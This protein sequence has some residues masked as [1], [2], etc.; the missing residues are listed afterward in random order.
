MTE[1]PHTR[2]AAILGGAVKGA[3]VLVVIAFV[4]V[5][6]VVPG[7]VIHTAARVGPGIAFSTVDGRDVVVISYTDDAYA[8]LASFGGND[9]RVTAIDLA[10]GETV[11][12]RGIDDTASAPT[13][14][15]AG[16]E[17]AYLL[18]FS[19]LYVIDL[20]DGSSVAHS[21]DIAGLEDFDFFP[22]EIIYSR[23]QNA[24]MLGSGESPVLE[25][26]L[27]TLEAVESDKTTVGT[28]SCVLDWRGH[29]YSYDMPEPVLVNSTSIEGGTLGFGLPTGA[30]PGTPGKRLSLVGAKGSSIA[31]GPETF[32]NGQFVAESVRNEPR[33]GACGTARSKRNVFPVDET[34]P[35]PVGISS[36]FAVVEHDV[37]ARDG[38]RA[39]SAVDTATGELLDSN[40]AEWGVTHARNIPS[41]GGAVVVDRFLT[42]VLPSLTVP[43]TSVVVLIAD[44]GTMQEIVLAKHGW[45][46]LPW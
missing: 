8:G 14:L 36:G 24:I 20:A 12:E 19:E 11:W 7:P 29:T 39:I 33:P 43:V 23:Q 37:S 10:T 4:A 6:F 45:F 41:G 5:F 28:W 38:D 46:G 18:D 15:A 42:G 16:D 1:R 2:I 26:A 21:E 30:A 3:V 40:T 22:A 17:Y 34:V 13:V 27:D 32:V 9:A 35:A 25:I 31:V 44:D